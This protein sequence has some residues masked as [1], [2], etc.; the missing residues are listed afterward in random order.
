MGHARDVR[1]TGR[2]GAGGG[3]YRQL[4]SQSNWLVALFL[5]HLLSRVDRA[6]LAWKRFFFFYS[7]P[8]QSL[9]HF[10]LWVIHIIVNHA[11]DLLKNWCLAFSV[12]ETA[13]LPYFSSSHF[14]VDSPLKTH[15]TSPL[16]ACDIPSHPAFQGGSGGVTT[17][18]RC[19]KMQ[20][21]ILG[22]ELPSSQQ[23]NRQPWLSVA[24]WLTEGVSE[25]V[26][27][28]FKC[29]DVARCATEHLLKY[30]KNTSLKSWKRSS[31]GDEPRHLQINK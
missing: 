23:G 5:N 29:Q 8:A 27:R 26:M 30:V 2:F 19:R 15:S 6:V 13:S 22:E 17:R 16:S 31:C 12:I 28:E 24:T 10:T 1:V 21:L 18:E 20:R 7:H 9:H 11:S 14:A 4:A 3:S 25:S